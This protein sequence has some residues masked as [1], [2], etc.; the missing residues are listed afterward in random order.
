M[1]NDYSRMTTRQRQEFIHA[2]MKFCGTPNICCRNG[3]GS[4]SGSGGSGGDPGRACCGCTE[5]QWKAMGTLRCTVEIVDCAT[6]ANVGPCTF[7][8]EGPDERFTC[9]RPPVAPDGDGV[10]FLTPA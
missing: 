4:G 3:S 6:G 1:A 2:V 8:M 9:P 5:A 7:D 10:L